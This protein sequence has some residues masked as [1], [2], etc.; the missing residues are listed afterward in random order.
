MRADVRNGRSYACSP[1][2]GLL[3]ISES[4]RYF[5]LIENASINFQINRDCWELIVTRVT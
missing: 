5:L 2:V 1:P 3:D 4:I